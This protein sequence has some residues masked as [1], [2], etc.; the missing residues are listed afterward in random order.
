MQKRQ[1]QTDNIHRKAADLLAGR[2]HFSE[3]LSAKLL[4]K[5]YDKIAID[6]LIKD[7]QV[8]GFLNDKDTAELYINELKN[9]K[10]SRYEVLTNMLKKGVE[11]TFAE[12]IL[13]KFFV[14]KDEAEHIKKLLA[15]KGF[16][17][18]SITDIR[19]AYAFFVRK[20]FRLENIKKVLGRTDDDY[21]ED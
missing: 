3:E 18:D 12:D 7:F 8:K 21:M 11:R 10:K 1:K 13:D 4:K 16:R 14:E 9:K 2:P 6:E 20:G 5:G 17:L 15:K 19:K